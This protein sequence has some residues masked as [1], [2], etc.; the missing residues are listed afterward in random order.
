MWLLSGASVGLFLLGYFAPI[1]GVG[2]W[3]LI[4]ILHGALVSALGTDA[5]HMPLISG[6]GLVVGL[7]IKRA[8]R[9]IP[10][11]F[12]VY[13]SGILLLML[14]SSLQG[15]NLERSF[16]SFLLYAKA[17]GLAALVAGV[18]RNRGQFFLL[19]QYLFV[20][21]VT[22][23]CIAVYQ[24]ISGSFAIENIYIQRAAG[25]REDPNDTAMLLV[26]AVPVGFAWASAK[27]SLM[28][29]AVLVGLSLT[30]VYAITLTGSRGGFL[31]LIAACIGLYMFKPTI[32]T[33]LLAGGIVVL[34]ALAAPM[35]YWQRIQT[36]FTGSEQH[37]GAS[38]NNRLLLQLRGLEIVSRN[39][40]FGV[41]PGNFGAAFATRETGLKSAPAINGTNS[42]FAVAHNLHLE[43]AAENG[44]ILFSL[45]LA[46]LVS[47][48]R[49]LIKISR[50]ERRNS[51]KTL[52]IP[53]EYA[54]LVSLG[55]MLM[56]GLFLSQGKNLVL[57]F[58]IGL[59]IGAQH[60]ANQENRMQSPRLVI[61]RE[62]KRPYAN[63]LE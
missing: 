10:P 42:E 51:A 56:A 8:W 50:D 28:G 6:C 48:S 45:W 19:A 22:G 21:L 14:L 27:K 60:F 5:T 37:G 7:L 29:R 12:A 24:K 53:F 16:L 54:I 47:L 43:L 36:I 44:V 58:L 11:R 20:G 13:L 23:A 30:V 2:I 52:E 59:A 18:V 61:G 35:S 26:A 55:A 41:G 1:H 57:W 38:I 32:S 34:L 4:S 3:L 40:V 46:L 17:I 62:S 31:A 39:L 63:L 33:S 15:M 49:A 9:G 25:I